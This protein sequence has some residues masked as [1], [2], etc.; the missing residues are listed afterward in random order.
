M[1]GY[2]ITDTGQVRS[3]NEDSGGVYYDGHSSLL[4]I[5]ADGMG[6]HQAGD[7]ASNLAVSYVKSAWENQQPINDVHHVESWLKHTVKKMNAAIFDLSKEQTAYEGMG[8]TVVVGVC[9]ESF[10]TIAHIGDSRAYLL[11]NGRLKQ[12]TSDHSLVNELIQ[13]GQLT[14]EEA[15]QHPNKNV[16]TRAAGTEETVQADIHTFDWTQNDTLL[17]CSDGLTN[18]VSDQELQQVLQKYEDKEVLL[19][20]LIHLA[21]E[22]GGEDN[23]TATL[24]ANS[25][26]EAGDDIC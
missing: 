18:K 23:I 22:R 11:E 14:E 19:R 12:L 3:I 7:V 10:I 4:A 9:T 20:E 21:N 8:T 17:F 2:F 5:V 26:S 1:Q 24:I 25:P 16:L 15:R 6:G 13:R